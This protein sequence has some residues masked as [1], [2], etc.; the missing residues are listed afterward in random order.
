M[1]YLA[2][3]QK[4][5]PPTAGIQQG[6]DKL[7]QG[8]EFAK[9]LRKEVKAR[10]LDVQD[11]MASVNHLYEQVS[12]CTSGND[13]ISNDI[14]IVRASKF[15]D[16]ERAALAVFFKI[17]SNWVNRNRVNWREDTLLKGDE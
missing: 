3:L 5:V 15:S 14:I 2:K 4:I 13:D 6:L 9:A 7:A 17:Q 10:K 12:K 1:V 11:V 8:R 16:N